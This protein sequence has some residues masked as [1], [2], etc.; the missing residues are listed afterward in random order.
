MI[1]KGTHRSDHS[2]KAV[3]PESKGFLSRPR[4]AMFMNSLTDPFICATCPDHL[5]SA[6]NCGV[7]RVWLL[8][9]ELIPELTRTWRLEGKE[10]A[11]PHKYPSMCSHM[12]DP[13][14]TPSPK[15]VFKHDLPYSD[16]SN[17]HL[18]SSNRPNIEPWGHRSVR[19]GWQTW[20]RLKDV[21]QA[22]DSKFWQ[23]LVSSCSSFLCI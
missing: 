23:I 9:K 3:W 21:T 18:H 13:L 15:Q 7:G 4:A 17:T 5:L 12:R 6:R 16:V 8:L 10:T 1:P 19:E 14:P 11:F 20:R 22:G 2:S